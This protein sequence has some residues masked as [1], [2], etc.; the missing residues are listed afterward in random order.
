MVGRYVAEFAAQGG[1]EVVVFSSRQVKDRTEIVSGGSLALRHVTD[2]AS[3]RIATWICVAP[4]WVLPDYFEAMQRGG[5]RRV[6]AMSSTSRFSKA[7]SPSEVDRVLAQRL[8]TAEKELCHWASVAKVEWV[9]LRPT[10]IYGD[11]LDRNVS[12]IARFVRRW[13]FFPLIGGGRGLRQPLHAADAAMFCLSAARAAEV[14]SGA[15]D[16][17]GG[18]SLSYREMVR[19]I[20]VA[21]RS[22]ICFVPVPAWLLRLGVRLVRVLPRF[23]GLS[24]AMVD[25]MTQDLVFDDRAARQVF[26]VTP[27]PFEVTVRDIS[28]I[29]STTPE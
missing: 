16:I 19:R 23:R 7:E 14:A 6:V 10:L 20:A 3:Q 2:I 26:G 12:D 9:I 29:D 13:H 24:P 28:A 4:I 17:C 11:G 8:A 18:E 1:E 5:V 21:A 27:R 25:R 22:P 15:F